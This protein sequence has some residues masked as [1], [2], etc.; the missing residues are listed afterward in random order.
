M[1]KGACFLQTCT[2]VT[3]VLGQYPLIGCVA[4]WSEDGRVGSNREFEPLGSNVTEYLEKALSDNFPLLV[5][6]F[7]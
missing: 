7:W 6:V 3:I 4:E 1:T 2:I 5:V